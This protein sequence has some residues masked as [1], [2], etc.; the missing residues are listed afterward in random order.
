MMTLQFNRL[1]LISYHSFKTPMNDKINVRVIA[2][3]TTAF[4]IQK[5]S[6]YAL[7]RITFCS[8]TAERKVPP[9]MAITSMWHG[10]PTRPGMMK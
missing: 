9:A 8:G 1:L 4:T 10:G 5:Q 2:V 3:I 7:G 6:A